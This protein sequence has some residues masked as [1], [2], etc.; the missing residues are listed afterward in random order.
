M[1]V[2]YAGRVALQLGERVAARLEGVDDRPRKHVAE[3]FNRLHA[4]RADIEDER[5]IR[6]HDLA[7]VRESSEAALRIIST[8]IVR[9]ASAGVDPFRSSR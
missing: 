7:H 2:R 1:E 9:S 6:Q 4:V 5:T 8:C 3:V